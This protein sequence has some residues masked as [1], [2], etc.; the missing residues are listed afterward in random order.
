MV[1][2]IKTG[3][4]ISRA[5]HYNERNVQIDPNGLAYGLWRFSKHFPDPRNEF[6]YELETFNLTFCQP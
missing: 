4:C 3:A 6:G 1:A 5:F 2:V